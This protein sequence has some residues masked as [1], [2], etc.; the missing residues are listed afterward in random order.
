MPSFHPDG[1]S[2]AL[3]GWVPGAGMSE[4]SENHCSPL[5]ACCL[6]SGEGL[7]REQVCDG[8]CQPNHSSGRL[9]LSGKHGLSNH[10]VFPT[11]G[12]PRQSQDGLAHS[13]EVYV[14]LYVSSVLVSPY[15]LS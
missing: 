11:A 2:Q 6:S 14:A 1:L 8:C 10:T 15:S 5:P 9:L 3:W 4:K 12:W 13:Y 7:A